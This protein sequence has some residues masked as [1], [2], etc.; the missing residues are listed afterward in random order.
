MLVRGDTELAT[1]HNDHKNKKAG[2]STLTSNELQR[3]TGVIGRT[4][5]C[6]QEDSLSSFINLH[7]NIGRHKEHPTVISP[8][9]YALSSGMRFQGHR[10]SHLAERPRVLDDL[11]IFLSGNPLNRWEVAEGL[12]A[13]ICLRKLRLQFTCRRRILT[14]CPKVRKSTFNLKRNRSKCQ[15]G[16]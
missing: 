6:R 8:N 11:L 3:L 1:V 4:C 14:C 15:P 7:F 5:Y 12:L 10:P 2:T 16:R 9:R 13:P